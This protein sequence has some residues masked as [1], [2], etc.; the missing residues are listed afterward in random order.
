MERNPFFKHP[1]DQ[2]GWPSDCGSPVRNVQLIY[3]HEE[4]M[5]QDPELYTEH[6]ALAFARYLLKADESLHEVMLIR[7]GLELTTL[8]RKNERKRTV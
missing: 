5:K 1:D 2:Y 8:R 3:F 4:Y 7:G 6:E